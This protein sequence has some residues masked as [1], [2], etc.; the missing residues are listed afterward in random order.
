MYR[1]CLEGVKCKDDICCLNSSDYENDNDKVVTVTV[2]DEPEYSIEKA[3]IIID[4]DNHQNIDT[5]NS[6]KISGSVL[7]EGLT[8]EASECVSNIT[9]L[10]CIKEAS[11]AEYDYDNDCK[12]TTDCNE[13]GL[14]DKYEYEKEFKEG[15]QGEYTA[16]YR[17]CL[18]GVKCKDGKCCEDSDEITITVNDEP[19]YSI[20]EINISPTDEQT[21]YAP[22]S[23]KISGSVSV[24]GLTDEAS[25]CVSNIKAQFCIKRSSFSNYDDGCTDIDFTNCSKEESL[26]KYEYEREFKEGEQGHKYTAIYR[27]CLEGV[28]CKDNKCCDDSVPITI[29]VYEIEEPSFRSDVPDNIIMDEKNNSVDIS[30]RVFV[31]GIT[32]Q[33]PDETVETKIKAQF[34]KKEASATEYDYENDCYDA[35][36]NSD[37]HS[38]GDYDEYKYTA[39]YVKGSKDKEV[40]FNKGGKYTAIYRFCLD[41]KC[42]NSKPITITV[43]ENLSNADF[44]S[45]DEGSQPI[46]WETGNNEGGKFTQVTCSD[47]STEPENCEEGNYALQVSR[48]KSSSDAYNK[49]VFKSSDF[50]IDSD[51]APTKITFKLAAHPQMTIAIVLMCKK[52]EEYQ[53]KFNF[54]FDRTTQF[55][56]V[57]LNPSMFPLNFDNQQKFNDTGINL[58][59]EDIDPTTL[60]GETCYLDFRYSNNRQFEVW[61]VFDDFQIVYSED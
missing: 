9:A 30:G 15:D 25:G 56:K 11:A 34:C 35:E 50:I 23:L 5:P 32:D 44:S 48:E 22:D 14:Y 17:F 20:D 38:S 27:F 51:V 57:N 60:L 29:N 18:E 39:T 40:T 10:F 55:W 59:D 53:P 58:V 12:P 33:T 47:F 61:A 28:K 21:I 24:P 36:I 49:T 7:V 13:D 41:E 31:N 46:G 16:I 37:C 6:L 3:N 19:E 43:R 54:A 2:K 42:K 1:F 26:D 52:G 45:W 8:D 4:P